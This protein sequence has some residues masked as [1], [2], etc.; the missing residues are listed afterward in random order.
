M[1]FK[2]Y[3]AKTSAK[4]GGINLLYNWI[5]YK[6]SGMTLLEVTLGIAILGIIMIPV[7]NSFFT[8]TKADGYIEKR[9][10]ALIIAERTM[11]EAKNNPK[12]ELYYN[13]LNHFSK[14]LKAIES[15]LEKNGL[16]TEEKRKGY[17]LEVKYKNSAH[18]YLNEILVEVAYDNPKK[19]AAD[20]NIKLSSLIAPRIR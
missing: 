19:N 14:V 2:K 16:T 6:N 5:I 1:I 8:T 4:K 12:L 10:Q 9:E 18:D 17:D 20:V 11:E 15:D 3:V 13:K 7:L